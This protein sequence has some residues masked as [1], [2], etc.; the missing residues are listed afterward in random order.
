MRL[1][2]V[3]ILVCRFS[4]SASILKGRMP[5]N[6]KKWRFGSC[7]IGISNC[8]WCWTGG[9]VGV[10]ASIAGSMGGDVSVNS[11]H[12]FPKNPEHFVVCSRSSDV[13]IMNMAG[14]VRLPSCNRHL[15]LRIRQ[16]FN[17]PYPPILWH[18][19][20]P[21]LSF[22]EFSSLFEACK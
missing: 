16:L 20:T 6:Y 9:S 17:F 14:Q 15:G 22:E 12:P 8:F 13:V 2:C 19:W 3:N 5:H 21:Y 10:G 4:K 7:R 11:I 18:F 1:L